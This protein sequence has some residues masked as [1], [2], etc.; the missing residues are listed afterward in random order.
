MQEEE[1]SFTTA[2]RQAQQEILAIFGIEKADMATSE[3]LDISQ[4]GDDN[5]ILL[6]VSAILQSNNTIAELSE[7]L[8]NIITDI[9]EDGVLNSESTQ[10]KIR[11][12]AMS[13]TL[14]DIR[15]HLE[16]RY[17]ELGVEDAT[18]PNAT[19]P[20]FEQYID[21][22]GDSFLNQDDD[23]TPDEFTFEAQVD[24]VLDTVVVSNMVTISGLKEGSKAIAVVS[25][26]QLIINGFPANSST[27][28]MQNGDQIQIT[29][30]SSSETNTESAATLTIGTITRAFVASTD[31]YSPDP[32][33]FGDVANAS[34]E[35]TYFS[36]T[37]IIS[38]LSYKV[39]E[40]LV[41]FATHYSGGYSDGVMMYK[42]TIYANGIGYTSYEG[43]PVS[44]SLSN[45]D[46]VYIELVSSASYSLLSK[47]P[48]LST[49][50][51]AASW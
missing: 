23:N 25:G 31:G 21:S 49:I 7:L 37:I 12:N 40:Q 46:Q 48:L 13:L 2:K 29:V 43:S 47:Q 42:A 9:R 44:V 1:K 45:G 5:A 24:V 19:I 8:A 10:E 30:R 51:L 32:F 27:S 35:T 28:Q 16:V 22:D 33:S 15:Q 17:E 18:I 41:S 39:P 14:T 20:N 11:V 50:N 38:S 3:V 36:D 6:A 26:G 34:L 4:D